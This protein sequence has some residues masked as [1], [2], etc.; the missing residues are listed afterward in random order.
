M[1]DLKDVEDYPFSS[2]TFA[3]ESVISNRPAFEETISGIKSVT[4]EDVIN[5]C[6]KMKLD[7]IYTLLPGDE[8]E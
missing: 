4:K 7:T 6:Q 2:L 5:V 8:N 3:I 1:N